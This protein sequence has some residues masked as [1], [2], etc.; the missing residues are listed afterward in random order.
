MGA[1]HRLFIVNFAGA[2]GVSAAWWMGYVQQVFAGDISHISYVI[3]ALF[4]AGVIYAFRRPHAERLT[5]ISEW[6]VTL[7][8]IGN[9]IGFVI[10]LSGIDADA[11]SS[12]EGAQKVASQLLAGMGVAF[13]STLVGAVLALWTSINKR[14]LE[15]GR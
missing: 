1:V 12:A 4:I 8:L 14:V 5:D 11:V 2:C 10:A 3:A 7:G 6:L 9:V 13:Y 15:A